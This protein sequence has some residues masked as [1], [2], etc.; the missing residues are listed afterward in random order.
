MSEK[1]AQTRIAHIAAIPGIQEHDQSIQEYIG[2]AVLVICTNQPADCRC[3]CSPENL[4]CKT[5]HVFGYRTAYNHRIHARSNQSSD[6][7]AHTN[8]RLYTLLQ[9]VRMF[10]NHDTKIPGIIVNDYLY[11][12]QRR[13]IRPVYF[14][15]CFVDNSSTSSTGAGSPSTSHFD[16]PIDAIFKRTNLGK[17][18]SFPYYGIVRKGHHPNP[19][20]N[21]C[22][23]WAIRVLNAASLS[24]PIFRVTYGINDL[25]SQIEEKGKPSG[26]G[27]RH[28]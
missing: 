4:K 5:N 10:S 18:P 8:P 12:N 13:K 28:D 1:T 7:E 16:S 22:V 14:F 6:G 17:D 27:I 26:I 19:E 25:I 20:I 9:F 11:F 23:S 15:R 21:N 2:H 3:I 24:S